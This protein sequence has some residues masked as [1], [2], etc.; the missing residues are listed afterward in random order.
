VVSVLPLEVLSGSDAPFVDIIER[1]SRLPVGLIG[2]ISIVAIINGGLIQIIMASRVLYGMAAQ[3]LAPGWLS[4]IN[5]RTRTPVRS[6]LAV[7]ML[8]LVL[9]LWLPLPTLA[10]FTS[11][12]VLC[13]FTLVNLALLKLKISQPAQADTIRVPFVVPLFGAL[14]SLVFLLLQLPSLIA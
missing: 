5:R 4:V 14:L 9:A 11:L 13:V 2:L 8:V 10:G 7:A 6:T 3:Q 12:L 1:H